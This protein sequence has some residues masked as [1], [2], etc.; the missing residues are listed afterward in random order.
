MI[1]VLITVNLLREAGVG[2]RSVQDRIDPATSS[3][4]LMLNMLA[5]R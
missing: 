5:T 4:R 2:I 1:D 3:G